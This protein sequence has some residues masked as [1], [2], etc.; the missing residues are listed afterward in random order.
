MAAFGA[1]FCSLSEEGISGTLALLKCKNL[2]KATY[3]VV[4]S[5]GLKRVAFSYYH[6]QR[7]D[8]LPFALPYG[9]SGKVNLALFRNGLKIGEVSF[10]V[11]N[12]KRG[13]SYITLSQKREGKKDSK[14]ERKIKP[15]QLYLIRK[16]LK[17]FTP[18]R[19]SEGKATFP[20]RVYRR[21]S[22]PFG[23]RRFINGRYRGFH[24]GVDFAAPFG[25][26]VFAS[27][28]GKVVLA[29]YMPLTGNTVV[30]DHGWG[31]LTLYAHLSRIEVREGQFVKRGQ[32][33]GKVGSTG[34]STGPHL[35]FGVYLNDVAVDPLG[36]LKLKLR[37]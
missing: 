5:Q 36:F 11:E 25:T 8:Y 15:S 29:R 19:F 6:P 34:R 3:K 37:P 10:F 7:E 9:W 26:A 31:L 32:E 27:L 28:S 4:L 22:S 1:E 14:R 20:I 17:T 13:A 12:P 24:K 21:I 18:K 33:I 23:I 16:V 35:H 30:I 2:E